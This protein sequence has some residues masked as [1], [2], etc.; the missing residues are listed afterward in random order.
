MQVQH[1]PVSASRV[2]RHPM[3][4]LNDHLLGETPVTLHYYAMDLPRSL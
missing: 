1:F 2:A 3:I 4:K